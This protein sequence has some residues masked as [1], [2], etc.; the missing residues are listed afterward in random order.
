VLLD[1]NP[2]IRKLEFMEKN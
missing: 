2:I 1:L